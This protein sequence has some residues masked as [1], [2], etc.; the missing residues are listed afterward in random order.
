MSEAKELLR[1]TLV[2]LY[3][4]HAV[5]THSGPLLNHREKYTFYRCLSTS[6]QRMSSIKRQSFAM[7]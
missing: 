4:N 7:L 1:L 3:R 2:C 5:L 6:W